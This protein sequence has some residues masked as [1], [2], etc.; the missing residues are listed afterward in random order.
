MERG[1]PGRS[2][3]QPVHALEYS[4]SSLFPPPAAARSAA[5]QEIR[6]AREDSDESQRKEV[7][8]LTSAA[9]MLRRKI[10]RR[11]GGLLLL[12]V[13]LFAHTPG[14]SAQTPP[15]EYQLKAVF[16]FN[17]AQFVEWPTNAFPDAQAPLVIGVLGTDPFGKDLDEVVR[18]EKVKGRPLVVERYRRIEDIKTCHMLFISSSEMGRLERILADL[19]G[20]NIL[21]VADADGFARRGVMICFVTK[22][23]KIR[24]EINRE[25]AQAAGLTISSKL[26][27][28]ATIVT[29]GKD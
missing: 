3:P 29:E 27:R 25:A 24:L 10:G 5:L 11:A 23:N 28:S 22:E 1:T 21:T 18:G 6:A 26:L 12:A 9:T 14:W 7:H 15:G 13:M 4:L 19:K 2:S 17:F 16:L 8:I 20:R